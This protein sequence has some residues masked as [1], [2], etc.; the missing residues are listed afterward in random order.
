MI[1][2]SVKNKIKYGSDNRKKRLYTLAFIT[3]V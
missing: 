2:E 1:A 3:S